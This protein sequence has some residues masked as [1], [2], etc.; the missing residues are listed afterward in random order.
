MSKKPW[1]RKLFVRLCIVGFTLLG[2]Y[3]LYLDAQ[4]K[5]RFSGSIWQV[6]AQVYARPMQLSVN[7]EI[8]RTEVKD[9]LALLGYRKASDVTSSGTYFF[10]TNTLV[11]YRRAFHFPNGYESARRLKVSW[12]GNRIVSIVDLSSQVSIKQTQLEPWL[13]SRLIT[14]NREDRMLLDQQSVPETLID[15]LTLTED[16]DFYHHHGIAP[17]SILR[18]LV[19]NVVA[20]K[21]VQGGSTLTQQLAKNVFLTRERSLVRKAKEAMMAI[22]IDARYSKDRI[23][24][25]YLNE[26][27]LGQNGDNA[28]HGFGLAAH[29]FFDRP[30]NELPIQNLALLVGMVKGP[31][32]YNP[33]RYP[34]RALERRNLVLRI[35]FENNAIA[36]NDYEQMILSPLGLD[37]SGTLASGKF[38]AFMEKVRSELADILAQPSLRE[39]GVKVFTT[40]DI[41]AQRRAEKALVSTLD[42]KQSSVGVELNGAIIVS[43]N[44]TG[45]IRAMVGGRRVGFKGFNRALNAYRPIGSLA[46]PIVYLTALEDP[47]QYNLATPL[48]DSPLSLPDKDGRTWQPQNAD[49]KFRGRVPLITGL[50]DSLNV[51][52]VRLGVEIGLKPIIDNFYRM[53][54]KSAIPNVPS[55]TLGAM[56]LSVF[57][58]NQVYQTLAN[59]GEYAPLHTVNSIVSAKNALLWKHADFKAQVVDEDATYLTNYALHQVTQTGT[60]KRVGSTFGNTFMAGKTGTT[61][62][63]RDSWFAGFDRRNVVTVWVGND[64]NKTI[65]LS[66]ASGAMPVFIAYQK[67]QEPKSLTQRFPS[68]LGIAHFDSHTGERIF[69]GCGS[70][71]SVPAILDVLPTEATSCNVSSPSTNHAKKEEK[72][73][74]WE[75]IFGN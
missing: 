21:T 1:K 20:G 44:Q 10:T 29:Y 46:K 39:S 15:A 42:N 30:L 55:I 73:S 53:G 48:T 33:L 59:A 19:A 23:L 41:N 47:I 22:A 40:I 26:V 67:L 61:N 32:Y 49:K 65:N 35:L 62:D 7:A 18:A 11:I 36:K 64:D 9:E 71:L 12:N 2:A 4:I 57:E 45:E 75:R 52:T 31:S 3:G 66:G 25:A 27:Y 16:K 5:H 28:I 38:P 72:V 63:Y 56:A 37:P 69:P 74:W 8:T 50:T 6:P 17:K 43:D 14:S 68:S 34:E 70:T 54:V 58:V 60:A 51:P 13:V 24:T